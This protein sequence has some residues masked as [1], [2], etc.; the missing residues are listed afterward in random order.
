MQMLPRVALFE[1]D[2]IRAMRDIPASSV[3]LVLCDLPYGTT[4]NKWDSVIPLDLLWKEYFRVLKPNGAVILTG[5]GPFTA[6]LITSQEDWFKYKLTWVKSKS[7]NF[8]NAKRQP[9]RRHEDICVFYRRQPTYNPQMSEGDAYDKGV[10]KNQL[11][12]SYGDFRPVHVKSDGGRLPTDVIYYKTA[13]SEGRVYHATQKP[14]CLGR[15]L[16]RT[17]SKPGDVILDNAFGSGSFIVAAVLEGRSAIGIEMNADIEEF[18]IGQ[19]DLIQVAAERLKK[20]LPC[21]L[22]ILRRSQNDKF[23]DTAEWVVAASFTQNVSGI[24]NA[25]PKPARRLAREPYELS[26]EVVAF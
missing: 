6:R 17:Y 1:A 2:C 21:D 23:C 13:E 19:I 11:T 16:I 4:Q 20:S 5:Q 7:T 15:Y 22:K 26:R 9:L 14:V 18:K 12:G 25:Q 24:S 3:N 10:R 8:L